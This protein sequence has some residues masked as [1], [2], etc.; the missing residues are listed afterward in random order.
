M[1]TLVFTD[2]QAENRR[3]WAE[4]LR[5]PDWQEVPSADGEIQECRTPWD[6][7]LMLA[8][9]HWPSSEAVI[10]SDEYEY[11]DDVEEAIMTGCYGL[12][13]DDPSFDPKELPDRIRNRMMMVIQAARSAPR[14][15]N[16][17]RN[18]DVNSI[19]EMDSLEEWNLI[20]IGGC[21]IGMWSLDSSPM[22]GAIMSPSDV[23]RLVAD[24]L[25]AAPPSLLAPEEQ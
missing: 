25:D 18:L 9:E 17:I 3:V 6:V 1:S 19:A 24:I 20:I 23:A 12:K 5:R 15:E 8:T 4:W 7:G 10:A 14:S 11:Q 2:D 16:V 22:S 21:L 13:A